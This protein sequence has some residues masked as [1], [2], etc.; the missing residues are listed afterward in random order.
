MQPLSEALIIRLRHYFAQAFVQRVKQLPVLR[1]QV[2][3]AA[4]LVLLVRNLYIEEAA[5]EGDDLCLLLI[6]EQGVDVLGLRV[7][8]VHEFRK[9]VAQQLVP[10]QLVQTGGGCGN[11]VPQVYGLGLFSR[12]PHRL[13]ADNDDLIDRGGGEHEFT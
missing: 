8:I 9:P 7:D 2:E 13:R 5:D 4:R 12:R 11:A 10:R 6:R 3:I 1:Q